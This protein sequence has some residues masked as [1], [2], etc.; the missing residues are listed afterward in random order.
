MS[1]QIAKV[2]GIPV[3]LHFT[4]VI[5]FFLIAWT[6]AS[7]FMPQYFPNLTIVQYWI[8]GSIGAI[9]L[10]ISV[11]LHELMHSVMALRYGIKVRQI[12]LFIFG[13][14]SEITEETRDF[15]KEFKIAIAGP[16]ASFAIAGV[17]AVSW[18]LVSQITPSEQQLLAAKQIV[19]GIL[20]YGAIINTMLGAFNLIPAFP[21]DGGRILRAGLVA[22]KKDFDS[23]TRTVAR[24]GIAISYGF[25]GVGFLTMIT[26]YFISGIWILLIGWF[27]NSGA[28]SYLSQHELTSVLAG[29]RLKDIMNTRVI[30]VRK[31]IKIDELLKEYFAIYMKSSFPVIDYSGRMLG[32]VTL[33][34]VH[35]T[36]EDKRQELTAGEIM[37]PLE[38]LVVM[39]PSRSADE[40]LMKM[41]RTRMGKV[42]V[43]DPQGVLLGLVSKT[44]IMNMASERQEF[45]QELKKFAASDS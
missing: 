31:D 1:F 36:P 17:L 28:Q 41:T 19:E 4:L 45:Q 27:I 18:W 29:V 32:M 20:L 13:G 15:R 3:R 25:M 12:I 30:A 22:W 42:F 10:F 5:V 21:L 7:S 40:A 8:M 2:K 34:R 24:V 43:C 35:E 26:G 11:L 37:I 16:A 38:D 33:K 14:V 23:A 44:D 6:L 9:I 39:L